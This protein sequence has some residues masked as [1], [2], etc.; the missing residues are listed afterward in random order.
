MPELDGYEATAEIR[1]R[2]GDGRHVPIIAMTANSMAEDRERCL[3]AGMD[4]Y[5]SKPI[6]PQL[7]VEALR[8]HVERPAPAPVERP[9]ADQLTGELLD[10]ATLAELRE[11]HGDGLRD[12]LE[13]YL[14]DVASQMPRLLTEIDHGETESVALSAH[15]LK[16]RAWPSA[17][18]AWE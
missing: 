4:D 3:A 11:L 16:D 7:L 9:Q 10:P 6:R 17:R 1:L 15:R 14:D 8:R 18:C 13:L 12:L 5:V 2:E